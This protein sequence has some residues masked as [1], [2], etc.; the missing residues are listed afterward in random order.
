MPPPPREDIFGREK[1]PLPP[2]PR[3]QPERCC[4]LK[5]ERATQ[6]LRHFPAQSFPPILRKCAGKRRENK[7]AELFLPPPTPRT[8][9]E[10]CCALKRERATQRLRHFPAQSFPP[11]SRK[12]AGKRRGNKKSGAFFA[13]PIYFCG[14]RCAGGAKR[15]SAVFEHEKRP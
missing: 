7:K 1:F 13:P 10:R 11:T 14:R 15:L 12:C 3:T 5:R 6:R 9:P 8:Q 4:A 2:T